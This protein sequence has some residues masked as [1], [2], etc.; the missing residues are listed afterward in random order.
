MLVFEVLHHPFKKEVHAY[1]EGHKGEYIGLLGELEEI[2]SCHDEWDAP[3]HPG[4]G[5]LHGGVTLDYQPFTT[6]HRWRWSNS[7]QAHVKAKAQQ[8]CSQYQHHYGHQFRESRIHD[9]VPTGQKKWK[10]YD[11][12]GQHARGKERQEAK[13]TQHN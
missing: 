9:A 4:V 3:Y 12:A 1:Y 7:G 2:P 5:G 6:H 8:E 11:D 13:Y 10:G